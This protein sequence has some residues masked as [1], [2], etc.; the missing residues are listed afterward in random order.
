V[1]RL[2]S[3]LRLMAPTYNA[4][5]DKTDVVIRAIEAAAKA[6]ADKR[7]ATTVAI[8]VV[9]D[10]GQLVLLERLNNTQITSVDVA[11]AKARKAAIFRRPSKE[12]EDQVRSGRVA[13][14]ALPGTTPLQGGLPIEVDSEIIA[15]IVDPIVIA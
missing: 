1:W 9:D 7:D 6:E 11:T 14:I 4:S 15:A 12:F 5:P 8:A 13:A 3:G 10:G 2:P